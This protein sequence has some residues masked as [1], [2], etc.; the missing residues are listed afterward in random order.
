MF[1]RILLVA[2]AAT[3]F[4]ATAGEPT[5]RSTPVPSID[6]DGWFRASPE[7]RAE[8]CLYLKNETILDRAVSMNLQNDAWTRRTAGESAQLHLDQRIKLGCPLS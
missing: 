2:I 8:Y 1:K 4:V 7:Y 3:S 5:R 6:L